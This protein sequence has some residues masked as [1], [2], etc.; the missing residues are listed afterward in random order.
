MRLYVWMAG[1]VGVSMVTS[2]QTGDAMNV[3]KRVGF[4]AVLIG[5]GIAGQATA[6]IIGGAVTSASSPVTG[7]DFSATSSFVKLTVPFDT[8][9][10]PPNT[11]GDDTFQ[12]TNLYGF[13]EDQNVQVETTPLAYDLTVGGTWPPAALGGSLPVG[14]TVASHYL[15]FDP[16]RLTDVTGWVEF[17]SDI[18]AVIVSRGLLADSDYLANTGVTYLNPDLRGLESYQ[19]AITSVEPRRIFLS[20]RAST[21]G[22]YIR[23]LTTFSPGAANVPEPGPLAL[24][25]LGCLAI[26]HGAR[27]GAADRN[28]DMPNLRGN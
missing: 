26:V 14:T 13:D 27:R 18:V 12:N 4:L 21:P 11:V 10:G 8:P 6:T 7:I 15:F 25:V 16:D 28:Q 9:V 2:M 3:S 22:D 1:I 20:F 19:D 24:L 5:V 17:D 23:V